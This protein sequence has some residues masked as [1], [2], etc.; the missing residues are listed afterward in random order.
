MMCADQ[1]NL[2]AEV[3]T[4][5]QIGVDALHLDLMDA[6]FTPNMP[7]GIEMVRQLRRH[8]ELPFD[9]HLMVEQNELFLELLADIDVQRISLHYESALHLNRLLESIRARGAAAGV[10]LSPATPLL[11]LEPLLERLDHVLLMTVSPGFAGQPMLP[12]ALRRIAACRQL[13]ESHGAGLPIQVDGNVSFARAPEMVA[14][15]ARCLVAGSSSL[16]AGPDRAANLRRLQA[17]LAAPPAG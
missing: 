4:L 14:A 17:V 11:V 7:L 15:G 10:A 8:T 1:C 12:G 13:L 9:I 6:H 16:F 2:A 5:E 3:R